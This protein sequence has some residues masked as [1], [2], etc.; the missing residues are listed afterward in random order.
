MQMQETDIS[1]SFSLD[2]INIVPTFFGVQNFEFFWFLVQEFVSLQQFSVKI[3]ESDISTF[4]FPSSVLFSLIFFSN[5]FS[6]LLDN[7]TEISKES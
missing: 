3:G 7:F 6:L 1:I 5:I 2:G 4:L